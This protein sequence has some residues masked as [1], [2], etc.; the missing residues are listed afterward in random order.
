M[1][2][3]VLTE[4]EVRTIV[5][6]VAD[7]PFAAIDIDDTVLAVDAVDPLLAALHDTFPGGSVI[8]KTVEVT[9]DVAKS[10]RG[11]K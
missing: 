11:K 10:P 1:S 6:E 5:D 3:P 8:E 4:P 9:P 7:D 2:R